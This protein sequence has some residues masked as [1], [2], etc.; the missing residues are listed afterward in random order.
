MTR[1][2]DEEGT[3]GQKLLHLYQMLMMENQPYYQSQLAKQL[4]C[5][6]QTIIRLMQEIEQFIPDCFQ[7]GTEK[8]RRWYCIQPRSLSR[9]GVKYNEVRY[10]T[11]CKELASSFLSAETAESIDHSISHLSQWLQ[12]KEA[13]KLS[14]R[15]GNVL[16]YHKGRI[17]YS[18]YG[19]IIDDIIRAIDGGFFCHLRYHA[20]N[21]PKP[22][23]H[24]FIPKKY[25]VLNQ[26]SYVYGMICDRTG[27]AVKKEPQCLAIHRIKKLSII[28][29]QPKSQVPDLNAQTFGLPWHEPRSFTIKFQPAAGVYV[30][31]R[32]WSPVQE[33]ERLEDGCVLLHIT[34]SSEPELM[35]WVRSFGEAAELIA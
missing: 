9:S 13:E 5:S 19:E 10:L 22:K 16:F 35:A 28:A 3:H 18:D 1:R 12:E 31:E 14:Q 27:T 6:P 4:K 7:T 2:K 30:K 8:G 34:T 26:V 29:D 25:I 23:S 32:I 33:I 11:L 20:I 21:A 24:Y 15:Q 17:D